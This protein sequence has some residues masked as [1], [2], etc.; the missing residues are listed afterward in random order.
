MWLSS[1]SRAVFTNRIE[2]LLTPTSTGPDSPYYETYETLDE[3]LLSYFI[4]EQNIRIRCVEGLHIETKIDYPVTS[5]ALNIDYYF[6]YDYP[7]GLFGMIGTLTSVR[8]TTHLRVFNNTETGAYYITQEDRCYD[9]EWKHISAERAFT[10]IIGESSASDVSIVE[11][12]CFIIYNSGV[13]TGEPTRI[14]TSVPTMQPWGEPSSAPSLCPTGQPSSSPSSYPSF[15]P[16]SSPS[17]QPSQVPTLLPSAEP[18]GQPTGLP[19]GVPTMAPS[20]LPTGQ[21]SGLPSSVPTWLRRLSRPGIRL[22]IQRSAFFI[23]NRAT[24]VYTD[25]STLQRT[26]N[27]PCDFYSD[28]GTLIESH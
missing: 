2:L 23:P 5:D 20:S 7:P 6:D 15:C 4:Y 18:T 16:S 17:G 26:Y 25:C 27:G 14:P 13:P 10:F 28:W 24:L 8:D 11:T 21:P 19:S 3:E 22:V 12:Q 9:K 1:R